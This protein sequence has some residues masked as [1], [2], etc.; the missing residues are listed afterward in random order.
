[1]KSSLKNTVKYQYNN[2]TKKKYIICKIFC[3][4]T[5][6]IFAV[7]ESNAKKHLSIFLLKLYRDFVVRS[8]SGRSF[9]REVPLKLKLH[10]YASGSQ[11]LV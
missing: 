8:S 6:Y 5:I 11:F 3:L 1:M 2:D 10:V 9:H 4:L 7:C